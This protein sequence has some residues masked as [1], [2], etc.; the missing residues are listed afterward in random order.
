[1]LSF[2]WISYTQKWL[3]LVDFSQKCSENRKDIFETG[4]RIFPFVRICYRFI[5]RPSS[6]GGAAYCVALCLSVCPS[7]RLSVRPVPLLLTLEH[8]SRVF[9][10]LADVRYLLFCLHVRAAYSTAISAAQ[11]C[12]KC[13]RYRRPAANSFYFAK[14]LPAVVYT[15]TRPVK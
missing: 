7:V 3:K 5:M 8:R 1:M 14:M 12:L 6:V 9:V 15:K 4:C 13:G 10:N 11:A 2:F